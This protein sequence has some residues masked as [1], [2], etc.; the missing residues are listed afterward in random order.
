MRVPNIDLKSFLFQKVNVHP[1]LQHF[2]R[3]RN[4]LACL[5]RFPDLKIVRSLVKTVRCNHGDTPLSM[6][7]WSVHKEIPYINGASS[8]QGFFL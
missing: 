7:R 1:R 5:S 6:P 3:S 2:G 8:N 4:N